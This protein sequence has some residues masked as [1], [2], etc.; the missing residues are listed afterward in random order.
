MERTRPPRSVTVRANAKV[1]LFL[2]VDGLRA[3][4]F[5]EI[6]TVYHSV[7][8]ADTITVSRA[9]SGVTVEC[10]DP[11]VPLDSTN[12]AARAAE[13]IIRAGIGREGA[14]PHPFGLRI[15]IDKRIPVGSGLGGGSADA[16][17]ALLATDRVAGLGLAEP[18]L[19]ELAEGLGAD[20]KFLVR[21]GCA[22][23]RGKGDNLERIDPLPPLPVVIVVPPVIVS[24]AWAYRSLKIP[25]TTGRTRLNIVTDALKKGEI[26]SL[27]DVLEND[28]EKLIF[29]RFPETARARDDLLGMGAQTALL[30]GSGSAVYG[31]FT[32]RGRAEA[33]G[34]TFSR[35]GLRAF[36]AAFAARG[37]TTPQ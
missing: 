31:I 12:L 23:G 4:G 25:L 28:F 36:V 33:C 2:K 17:G 37:V 5:H 32:D 18:E 3:D 16:A 11:D 10:S 14:L 9:G 29:D 22:V 34:A 27:R 24:T 8:L 15:E 30:S 1:N 13:A 20:V 19:E 6:E 26:F 7:T 21:G 35:R